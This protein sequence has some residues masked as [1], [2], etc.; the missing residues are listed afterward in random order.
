MI[1][2]SKQSAVRIAIAIARRLPVQWLRS[3]NQRMHDFPLTR[4]LLNAVWQTV[5]DAPTVIPRGPLAGWRFATGGGQPGYLLG[6]S[7]P[8]LQDAL[9]ERVRKGDVVYDI[10]A[11]VGF[12]SLLAARLVTPVGRVYAF[13]PM[14]ANVDALARNL[15]LNDVHHAEVIRSAVS[16]TTGQLRMSTGNNQATGHLAERGD[17][18][19]AVSSTTVDGFVAAGK[20]PPDLVKIDVEG[21]EDRVLAGM[22]ETLRTHRPAIL[23]ELHY[24]RTDPRREAISRLLADVGYTEREL[25]LDGGSMPHLLALPA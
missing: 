5:G 24:D 19:V 13:E 25:P 21:A 10:G 23:C 17:D 7:E 6:A 15:T 20:L 11:N 12:F 4:R 2:R 16:D 3:I 14:E 1:T 8:D 18:L 22:V 9:V